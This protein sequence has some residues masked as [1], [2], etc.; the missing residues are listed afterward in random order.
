MKK[1]QYKC[2]YYYILRYAQQL[3]IGDEVLIQKKFE[4]CPEK[5]VN[6]SDIS[7]TGKNLSVFL[8]VY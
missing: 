4:L 1:W 2:C 3:S 8:F 7:M 6:V 5:V